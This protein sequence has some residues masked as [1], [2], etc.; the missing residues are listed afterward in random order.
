[1][2]IIRKINKT[3]VFGLLDYNIDHLG[4][5]S[6]GFPSVKDTTHIVSVF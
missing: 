6:S 2:L 3:V 1:M 4:A 5:A